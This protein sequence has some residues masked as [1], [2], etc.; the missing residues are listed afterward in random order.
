M[1]K[2]PVGINRLRIDQLSNGYYIQQ[3][4]GDGS[5]DCTTLDIVEEVIALDVEDLIQKVRNWASDQMLSDVCVPDN[6]ADILLGRK[7]QAE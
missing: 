7:R 4:T 6:G 3:T 2:K 5:K 1:T